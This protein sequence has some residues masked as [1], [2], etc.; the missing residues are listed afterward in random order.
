MPNTEKN[1]NNDKNKTYFFTSRLQKINICQEKNY[2]YIT[3]EKSRKKEK[4][5]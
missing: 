4:N 3:K 5:Q 1:T 2:I